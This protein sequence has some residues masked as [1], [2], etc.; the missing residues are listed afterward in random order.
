MSTTQWPSRVVPA[1]LSFLAIYNPSL[2]P[3]D[4]TFSD[5]SVFYCSRAANEARIAAK[6]HGRNEDAVAE[7]LRQEENEKLRQIG[8]AQG[9]VDFAKSFSNG[10]PVDS[11]ETE[12]SRIVLQELEKG[13]WILASVDL[14]QLPS[15]SASDTPIKAGEKAETKPA[16]EYSSREVSPP[17]LLLSQLT[18]AHHIFCLHHGPSLDDLYV[19]LSRDKFCSTLE[20]FWARF[21]RSWDVLLHG[22]PAVDLFSG[23]KLASGGE[24]GFGVGEEDWGSGERAVLEDIAN[25]TEGMVDLLVSRFGEPAPSEEEKTMSEGEALPWMG[26]GAHP[27]ASDGI[28]FGGVGYCERHSVRDL[29]LWMR[30]IYA[31]GENAY[32]VRDNPVRERRKRRRKNLP[33]PTKSPNGNIDRVRKGIRDRDEA[34]PQR[35]TSHYEQGTEDDG[36]A[37]APPGLNLAEDERP[38]IPLPIATHDR[39]TTPKQTPSSHDSRPDDQP[40]IATTAEQA[41]EKATRLADT[42]APKQPQGDD[43]G[44]DEPGTTLGIPDQYMKYLTFGLSTFG[45]ATSKKRPS[46]SRQISSNHSNPHQPPKKESNTRTVDIEPDEAPAML[47]HLDPMPDGDALKSRIALQKRQETNGY[48]LVGLSGDLNASPENED[49][50]VTD[51]SFQNDSDGSRI[52]LRT[53]LVEAAS[54]QANEQSDEEPHRRK[55]GIEIESASPATKNYRRL[56]VLIYVH[57]PFVY[58]FLFENRTASLSWTKFYKSLHQN[59][60]PIHKALLSSTDVAKVEQRIESSHSLPSESDND[61]ASISSRNTLPSKGPNSAP[62]FDLIWDPRLLTLHTSVPNIPEPGTPAAEGIFTSIMGGGGASTS[63]W[64]R[65]DALN[66]HSQILNTLQSV[67]GRKN[68]VERTSK[69]SRGWWVVWMKVPPSAPALTRESESDAATDQHVQISGEDMAVTHVDEAQV[70]MHRVA[71]LVR[72]ASDAPSVSKVPTSSRAMSSMFANMSL[73]YGSKEED[74]TGGSGAGWGPAA[75]TGGIGVDARRYVEGLLSLNR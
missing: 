29:S 11:I 49:P 15:I 39:T 74:K 24:L 72:K 46:A 13:W 31:N 41:L 33:E 61:N 62:I 19:R 63:T 56:R 38:Q 48:F 47:R 32:G 68:E 73:G 42:T 70:D 45:K 16:I 34:G 52:V 30:H 43:T 51:D 9:M 44:N 21:S 66:V 7:T 8:L 26:S 3:T 2:G 64:T 58:C 54:Q 25:R 35:Q 5:Q 69:T 18:Q 59:L 36:M 1:Q 55:R 14:T 27:V 75:L 65:V 17:A 67:R 4:D 28:I 40:S 22:N 12:K 50:D 10:A 60:Q 20:R 37:G 6:K 23:L 53:I 57:R 71:F